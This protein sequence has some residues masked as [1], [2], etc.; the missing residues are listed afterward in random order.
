MGWQAFLKDFFAI[1]YMAAISG[2]LTYNIVHFLINKV[3]INIIIIVNYG[4]S[5]SGALS[6]FSRETIRKYFQPS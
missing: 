5:K 1:T 6:Y 4:V 2:I 3:L